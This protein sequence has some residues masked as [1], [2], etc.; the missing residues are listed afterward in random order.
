MGWFEIGQF[1]DFPIEF[2]SMPDDMEGP[3]GIALFNQ[4]FNQFSGKFLTVEFFHLRPEV[5][6]GIFYKGNDL[7]GKE[8]VAF[9]P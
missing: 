3:L 1:E 4:S 7:V 8:G 5:G 2:E 6:L 9:I